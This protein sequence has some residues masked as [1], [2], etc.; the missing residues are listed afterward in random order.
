MEFKDLQP[1]KKGKGIET[2]AGGLSQYGYGFNCLIE[3]GNSIPAI[4]LL[5]GEFPKM[6]P[7]LDV[8]IPVKDR[9]EIMQCVQS[10]LATTQVAKVII[11][12]GGSTDTHCIEALQ[13]LQQHPPVQLI[14]VPT[15]GFNKS[16]LIN[17]GITQAK[18]DL[19]LISDADI[20]WN[21]AAL[22]TL[23]QKVLANSQVICSIKEVEESQPNS[24]ALKRDRYTYNYSINQGIAI[25]D[26]VPWSASV[27]DHRPGCGLICAKKTTLITLG[28]YKEIFTGWGWED[29]DLLIRANVLG[30]QISTEGK[31]IHLSHSDTVRNQ[32]HDYLSPMQTRNRNI[33]TCLQALAE[34]IVLGDLPTEAGYCCKPDVIQIRLPATLN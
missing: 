32:H 15:L 29:Q 34:G 3:D 17:Q 13:Y 12:D 33:V 18:S 4:A 27:Q 22:Q 31:V 7:Q 21:E 6:K 24:V 10:L 23:V 2:R 20:I 19:L 26:I 28:G 25:I 11:C 1:L 5:T 16:R 30:F 8:I 9:I 14:H